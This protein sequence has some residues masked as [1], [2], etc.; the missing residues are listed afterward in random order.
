M[1]TKNMKQEKN[2]KN[3]VD[4]ATFET[5]LNNTIVSLETLSKAMDNVNSNTRK[6]K[7]SFTQEPI[8]PFF[9]KKEKMELWHL[10]RKF[11]FMRDG[12]EPYIP[13]I[14]SMID[15]YLIK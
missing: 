13:S 6:I 12:D 11:V 5:I 10:K 8:I 15:D 3:V 7:H 14:T 9:S 1:E 2:I 4:S